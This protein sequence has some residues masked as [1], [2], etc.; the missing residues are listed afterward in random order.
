MRVA[1]ECDLG[2]AQD[3]DDLH[4]IAVRLRREEVWT[5][6]GEGRVDVV[7]DDQFGSG[8][9]GGIEPSPTGVVGVLHLR[10]VESV[11]AVD[12]EVVVGRDHDGLGEVTLHV[13]GL[14]ATGKA[15]HDD[16]LHV[17]LLGERM[18]PVNSA[19]LRSLP[20]FTGPSLHR[21]NMKLCQKI[22][23]LSIILG[24][25]KLYGP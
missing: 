13:V 18:G 8:L 11:L 21:E 6:L 5:D 15:A 17:V 7:D 22:G 12:H 23:V 4:G 1:V 16:D 2:V 24:G 20:R 14:A 3:R 9:H 10:D 19:K 25:I